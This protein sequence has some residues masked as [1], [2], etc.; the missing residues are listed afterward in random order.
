M[1]GACPEA[2][3]DVSMTLVCV[4]QH[5]VTSQSQFSPLPPDGEESCKYIMHTLGRREAQPLQRA[6]F[7]TAQHHD[8]M[9]ALYV[10]GS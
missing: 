10:L 8:R 4:D 7:A 1:T 5:I 2:G 3:V 9:R 6:A